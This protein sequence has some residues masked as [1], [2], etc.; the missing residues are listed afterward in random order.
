LANAF[1]SDAFQP[2]AFQIDA[3]PGPSPPTPPSNR[4]NLGPCTCCGYYY[5]Y[6]YA[7]GTAPKIQRVPVGS[8]C[9]GV[10]AFN[11]FS[12]NPMQETI[13]GKTYITGGQSAAWIDGTAFTMTFDEDT[14][15]WFGD[16]P[17]TGAVD[18]P[19]FRFYL[20][21]E[22]NVIDGTFD[23]PCPFCCFCFEVQPYYND[24]AD[25]DDCVTLNTQIKRSA[26]VSFFVADEEEPESE[27]N[28]W[29]TDFMFG[30][31]ISVDDYFFS[32]AGCLTSDDAFNFAMAIRLSRN[33]LP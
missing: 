30:N 4:V 27:L 7:Y 23:L 16:I 10:N 31:V 3:G 22:P 5:S 29:F 11:F 20:R 2:D 19:G 8:G 24:P 18:Q 32:D 1:Q 21:Q 33:P 14:G 12:E 13:H 28:P 9:S 25:A 17:P 15:Y 26:C 6:Y